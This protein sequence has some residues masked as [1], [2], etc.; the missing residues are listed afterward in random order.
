VTTTNDKTVL[1]KDLLEAVVGVLGP[2]RPGCRATHAKGVNLT[3]TFTATPRAR[4]LTRAAH[5]QG[6]PVPVLVR[7]SDGNPNPEQPDAS[8]DDPRGMAVSFHL[9]DGS[10]TDLVCQNWP[11]F[12][13]GTPEDFLALLRAQADGP[14]A[15]ER[16]LADRPDIAESAGQLASVGDPPL[17]W[18]TMRFNSMVAFK[19]VNADGDAQFVRF[20]L[21]PEAGSHSLPEAERATAD[22]D[23]LM[24][25]ILDE[26]PVRYRV[27]AQL[28]ADGDQTTDSSKAWPTDR[29]WADLGTIEIT[30]RDTERE[31]DG[32]ILVMDPMRL[33][34]GIE[35]SDDPILHIR[36]YVYAESVRRRTGAEPPAHLR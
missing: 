15:T 29:E 32:D 30:G 5:M 10:A 16:F 9:P 13:A 20:T 34:D 24:T 18:A 14:E 33:T 19:L 12:P 2:Q 27:T 3:G 36:P 25:G 17:S 22:R 7:F 11:V 4:E 1:A 21:V 31:R 35:P 8:Q 28:A 6:D 26:L 23:Y